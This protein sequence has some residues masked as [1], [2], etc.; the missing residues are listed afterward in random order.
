VS[1]KAETNF[2]KFILKI[3]QVNLQLCEI[4]VGVERLHSILLTKYFSGDQIKND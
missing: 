4:S 2:V 3:K 1:D